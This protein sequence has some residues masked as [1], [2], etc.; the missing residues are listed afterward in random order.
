MTSRDR[1]EATESVECTALQLA[2][3]LHAALSADEDALVMGAVED[4]CTLIDGN[5]DLIAVALAVLRYLRT[6]EKN[7]E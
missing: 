4:R 3:A 6:D 2:A 5:F 1:P 7:R